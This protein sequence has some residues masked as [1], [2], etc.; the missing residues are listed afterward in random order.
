MIKL[1]TLNIRRAGDSKV[2]M[3]AV[4]V[5]EMLNFQWTSLAYKNWTFR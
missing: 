1:A 3:L 2:H 4:T 5:F